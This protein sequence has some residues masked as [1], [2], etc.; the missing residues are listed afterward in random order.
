MI[1]AFPDAAQSVF[2]ISTNPIA[3]AGFIRFSRLISCLILSFAVPACLRVSLEVVLVVWRTL[4]QHHSVSLRTFFW[5]SLLLL[6]S[7]GSLSHIFS[8]WLRDSL[9]STIQWN[10]LGVFYERKSGSLD[11][12]IAMDSNHEPFRYERNALPV[13]LTIRS[14]PYKSIIPYNLVFVNC[15]SHKKTGYF[16]RKITRWNR[17]KI[18]MKEFMDK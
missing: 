14:L 3:Y 2:G 8:I 10:C 1:S 16:R 9:S 13:E 15:F 18:W 6:L 5:G 4:S 11:F 7:L 17:E 12:W